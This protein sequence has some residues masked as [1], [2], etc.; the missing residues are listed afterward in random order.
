MP[1]SSRRAALCSAL[2][3]KLRD[4]QLVVLDRIELEAPKTKLMA[5][6][7]AQLGVKSAL[8]VVPS[9][10]EVLERASRNLPFVKVLRVEG[11]NVYDIL[12]YDKLLVTPATVEAL[13]RRLTV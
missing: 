3:A 5:Q 7:V 12:R 4:G 11:A 6:F 9:K 2:S 1:A 10:D 13:Q 8:I